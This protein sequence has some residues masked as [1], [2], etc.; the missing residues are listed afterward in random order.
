[1]HWNSVHFTGIIILSFARASQL[2]I[3]MMV[4]TIFNFYKNLILRFSANPQ[5]YQTLV[6]AKK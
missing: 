2:M 6:P 3:F 5:K 4:C 1:M